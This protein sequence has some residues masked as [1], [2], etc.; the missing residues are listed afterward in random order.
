VAQKLR[1]HLALPYVIDQHTLTITASIGMA[2]H[3]WHG[4]SKNDLIRRADIAMY[5]AKAQN[6]SRLLSLQTA[7]S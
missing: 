6:N 5:F 7:V 2:V 4:S 1:T 3:P